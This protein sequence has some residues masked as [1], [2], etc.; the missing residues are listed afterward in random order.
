FAANY[1]RDKLI[2]NINKK[3]IEL[4]NMLAGKVLIYHNQLMNKPE[5]KK[6][7]NKTDE[8]FPE[9]RKSFR[10]GASTSL[11]DDCMKEAIEVT[12]SELL[13]KLKNITP[14]TR[15]VE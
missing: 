3:V 10:K 11:T 13:N 5:E 15:K 9:Q 6:S 2:S 8:K 7:D 12:D 4:K 14:I 1:A